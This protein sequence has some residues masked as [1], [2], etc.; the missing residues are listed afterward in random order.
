ML[1]D[2]NMS[3][4][5]IGGQGLKEPVNRLQNALSFNYYANTEVY[6][7]RSV[8]TEERDELNQE[9]WESIES[10]VSF[11]SD[12]RPTNEDIPTKGVT[13]GT[14][15][16]DVITTYPTTDNATT[17]GQTSF[18][19]IM[20]TAVS[21]VKNYA[22]SITDSLNQVA[23]RYSIDGLAYFTDERNYSDGK[24]L[25]YFTDGFTGTTTDT[26]LFGKPK[27]DELQNKIN[28]L[29][30]E[31]IT[32]VN[33]GNSPL[34]KKIQNKNFTN[35]D[36]D[37]Y[38]FNIINLINETKV[39]Y[40]SDYMSV[41]PKVVNNQLSLVSTIDKISFVMT[42]TDGFADK[43]R[44]IQQELSATDNVDKTSKNATTT[45]EE[46]ENDMVTLST[47][48]QEFYDQIFVDN[49]RLVEK[50]FKPDY[51]FSIE[52][53]DEGLYYSRF[54]NAMYEKILNNKETIIQK[55]LNDRLS[56]INK[57]DRYVNNIIDDLNKDYEKVQTKTERELNKFSNRKS[58]R[59]FNDYSPFTK[60]KERIFYYIDVP[61]ANV[62]SIKDG[63]FNELYSGLNTGAK[64]S[65]NGKTTFN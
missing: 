15:K 23:T 33:D 55:L 24:T 62:N 18:K 21:D 34:L 4:F 51:S 49:K 20:A 3:F 8:V 63:Y 48:L 30:D 27:E 11:G 41:M 9:I 29:F 35:A 40:I 17:S 44:N 39:N 57:W 53:Q 12:N 42:N 22:N 52:Y 36:I 58:V 60:E 37:L 25:G 65:Y 46:M 64:T 7:D 38:K 14:I 16:S 43:A 5:M 28:N 13:I 59:K 2:V 50:P 1:A 6:D 26:N 32:D 54:M 61:K 45:Y 19:T 47:D 31:I 56:G 10:T